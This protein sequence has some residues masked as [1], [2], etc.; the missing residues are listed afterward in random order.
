M[1]VPAAA[2][3][4]LQEVGMLAFAGRIISGGHQ[5]AWE[6]RQ[7]DPGSAP[8]LLQAALAAGCAREAQTLLLAHSVLWKHLA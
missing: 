6:V 8:K 7:E 3:C 2:P 1:G 4:A 5:P